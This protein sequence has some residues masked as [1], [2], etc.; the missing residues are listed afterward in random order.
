VATGSPLLSDSE[1]VRE[2]FA[3]QSERW[4]DVSYRS[5]MPGNLFIH[6]EGERG[7]LDLLRRHDLLPLT[8]R[9][10]LDVG[11]GSGKVL[12]RMLLY[13]AQPE[14]LAGVD[15]L[16]DEVERARRLT[17]HVEFR[18]GDATQLPFDEETFDLALAF[19][20]FTSMRTDEARQRAADEVRRVLKPGGALLWY[21]FW[22][23][24]R[25]A[26]V[27]P[28]GLRDIRRLFPDSEIDARRITLA[29]P[30]ARRL[31][32]VSWLACSLLDAVP[33]LRTHWLALI[34]LKPST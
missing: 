13:G 22:V 14:N 7:W 12:A 30:V 9:R 26:D 31:A 33:L 20:M 21:D 32:G 27:K 11:C 1:E 16:E 15:L 34:R 6:Q 28:L 2:A 19:T 24:P 25:N 29:P 8:E 5:W 10:I 18:V 4:A 17:P 23:N 3:R